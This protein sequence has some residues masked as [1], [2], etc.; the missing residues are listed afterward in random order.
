MQG[1]GELGVDDE[2]DIFNDPLGETEGLLD[3][4]EGE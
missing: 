2:D 3:G 1:Y 4:T